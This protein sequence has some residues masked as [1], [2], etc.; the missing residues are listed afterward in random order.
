MVVRYWYAPVD[1]VR[2]GYYYDLLEAAMKTTEPEFGPYRIER[3]TAPMSSARWNAEAIR[4]IRVNVLWSDVGRLGLSNTCPQP[5]AMRS[6]VA[7]HGQVSN[8]P[9]QQSEI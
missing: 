1:A 4:G 3:E 5:G 8:K 9:T 2:Y 7:S 6:V